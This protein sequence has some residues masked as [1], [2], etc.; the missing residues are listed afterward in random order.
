MLLHC[1]VLQVCKG[2]V[3][4]CGTGAEP[5]MVHNS[6]DVSPVFG[7]GDEHER[8]EIPGLGG[9]IFGE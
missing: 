7:I 8:Q 6:L 1:C 3:E 9:D 4:E 2:A 5:T